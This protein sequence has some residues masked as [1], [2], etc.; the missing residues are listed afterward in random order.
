M[1]TAVITGSASGIGAAT[2]SRLEAAGH[3]VIGIDL[4]GSDIVADLSTDEGRRA[5]VAGAMDASAGVV[6]LLVT[7]AGV[8]PPFDPLA[9]LQINWLGTEAMLTGLHGALADAPNGARVVAVASNATTCGLPVDQVVVEQLLNHDLEGAGEAIVQGDEIAA[10]A[11]AYAASKTAVAR[12]VRRHAPTE[13]WAGNGIRLNAI[14]PGAVQ[15][16]LL[17]AGLDD[18]HLGPM[19]AGFPVPTGGWA[20]PDQI[21]MWIEFML[22]EA[23]DYMAG[24]VVFVDGGTDALLRADAWPTSP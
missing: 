5:A 4:A 2:A 1:G 24:A 11:L 22:S 3:R 13:E 9:T 12:F 23:V 14:A 7:S 17:Q 6:D 15:T 8:G 21:A 16:P 10:S 19:I 20:E 18:P